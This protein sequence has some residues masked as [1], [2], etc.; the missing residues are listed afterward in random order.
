MRR[1]AAVL[2]L[3][4]LL[5]GACGLNGDDSEP[6]DLRQ[7][8][9]T[10]RTEPADQPPRGFLVT[11]GDWRVQ[12]GP[13][14]GPNVLAQLAASPSSTYNVILAADLEA[15]DVALS[16]RLFPLRGE[17]DQGGGLVWRAKDGRNYYV[18]RWNPLESNFRVYKVI[19]GNRIQLGDAP[20][21]AGQEWHEMSVVMRGPEIECSL[22][23][24]RLL[25]VTD[26]DLPG[27]GRVGL[28]TKADAAT[29]FSEL[30]AQEK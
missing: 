25:V 21:P 12:P 2:M 8:T 11:E 9:W 13:E 16:T 10:F 7:V 14:E 17:I 27:A 24:E 19:D 30:T 1:I 5:L 26:T 22:D 29:V 20:A 28:W 6:P 4:G 3:S 15:K 23:G 18:C